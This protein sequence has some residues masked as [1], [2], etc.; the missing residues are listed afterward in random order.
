MDATNKKSLWDR[1]TGKKS[2]CGCCCGTIIEEVPET[3][4]ETK[5]EKEHQNSEEVQNTK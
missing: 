4:E 3:T 5:P 2:D 1:L